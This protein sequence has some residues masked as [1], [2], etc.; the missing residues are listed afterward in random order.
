MTSRRS[1]ASFVHVPRAADGKSVNSKQI[2]RK[3]PPNVV[4][5]KA[6]KSKNC[7]LI[8]NYW[9]YFSVPYFSKK[10]ISRCLEQD[11]RAS[12]KCLDGQ[13]EITHYVCTSK[14]FLIKK[15]LI[16]PN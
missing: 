11:S 14:L 5:K 2:A 4:K 12:E 8:C 7:S 16:L 9:K 1:V 10:Q 13:K 15:L 6:I 3:I